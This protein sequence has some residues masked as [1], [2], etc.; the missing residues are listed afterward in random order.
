MFLYFDLPQ[1]SF[2]SKNDSVNLFAK[3]SILYWQH[4]DEHIKTE[5][6]DSFWEEALSIVQSETKPS[7]QATN[8]MERLK[9]HL[10]KLRFH[11]IEAEKFLD[12]FENLDS[13]LA[14]LTLS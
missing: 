7:E 6:N 12:L 9:L 5:Y 2:F 3:K 11:S 13:Q 10:K 4:V 1:P 14:L 8:R